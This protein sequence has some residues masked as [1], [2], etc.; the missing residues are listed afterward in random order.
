MS[1]PTTVINSFRTK[2]LRSAITRPANTTAY[3]AGDAISAATT[4]AMF[5]F[6]TPRNGNNLGGDDKIARSESETRSGVINTL[7]LRSSANQSTKL[8]ARLYLFRAAPAATADNA[9]WGPSDAEMLDCIGYIEIPAIY[10][11]AGNG[12]SGA[13]G[14][15]IAQIGN[16]NLPYNV[17]AAG[18]L[19][20]QL[21]ATAA[22][23]P[24]SGEVLSADLVVSID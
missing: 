10:W 23:T 12:T 5:V 2:T 9:A 17:G 24:V 18:A 13:G 14:N 21:V 15:A 8:G 7:I 6:G 3:A 4:N 22:Y 1:G 19:Y 16:L 11:V 20:G